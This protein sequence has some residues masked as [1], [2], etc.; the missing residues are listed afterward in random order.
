MI[1]L[2]DFNIFYCFINY[3]NVIILKRNHLF[4]PVFIKMYF[5]IKRYAVDGYGDRCAVDGYGDSGDQIIIFNEIPV[6]L[7]KC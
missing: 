2:Y 4:C 5:S 3:S 7:L 6:L 1:I